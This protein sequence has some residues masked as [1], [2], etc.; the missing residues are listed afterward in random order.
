MASLH[1]ELIGFDIIKQE[2][3]DIKV[4]PTEE[5]TL[6][7]THETLLKQSVACL[8]RTEPM[9]DELSDYDFSVS[10]QTIEL[11]FPVGSKR[12]L[13][14]HM[15]LLTRVLDFFRAKDKV[16]EIQTKQFTANA[17]V[18]LDLWQSKAAKSK[19]QIR[20]LAEALGK[21]EYS[22]FTQQ[23]RLSHSELSWFGD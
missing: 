3:E 7:K 21:E 5:F 12:L 11:T 9:L 8:Q 23:F 1:R 17:E 13:S 16:I 10:M 14:I 4:A 19:N 15:Q 2:L 18:R 22:S 6:S 20:T